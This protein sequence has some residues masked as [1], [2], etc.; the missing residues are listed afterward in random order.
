MSDQKRIQ[1]LEDKIKDQEGKLALL[2]ANFKTWYERV[3]KDVGYSSPFNQ[4]SM[5][6]MTIKFK[7]DD[8]RR[9]IL[10]RERIDEIDEIERGLAKGGLT[11]E[12]KQKFMQ[13]KQEQEKLRQE[14][15]IIEQR[16]NQ[17]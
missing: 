9:E 3:G 6:K 11:D 14:L 1:E 12:E 8:Y 17:P 7:I 10:I 13:L 15:N 4:H 5:A 2:E 16:N